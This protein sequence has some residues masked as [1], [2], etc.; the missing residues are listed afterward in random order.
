M[1]NL[2]LIYFKI[3]L[4]YF[5]KVIQIKLI[6][7][8]LDDTKRKSQVVNQRR[9]DKDQNKDEKINTGQQNT[10]QK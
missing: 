5:I 6:Y 1:W 10:A 4:V 2:K 3:S 8:M 9:A 7:D